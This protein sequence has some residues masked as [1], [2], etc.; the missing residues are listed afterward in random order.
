[1]SAKNISDEIN[2]ESFDREN[3]RI[4]F[5]RQFV[6]LQP[7]PDFGKQIPQAV[8]VGIN[9]NN[10]VAISGIMPEPLIF[11]PVVEIGQIVICQRLRN[12][13]ADR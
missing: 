5:D 4:V 6:G 9:Y 2:S 1:M 10:V 3:L 8:L 7:Y 12:V 13:V 11:D